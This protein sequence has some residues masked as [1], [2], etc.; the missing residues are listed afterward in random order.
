MLRWILPAGTLACAMFAAPA[1]ATDYDWTPAGQLSQARVS[2]ASTVLEDGRVLVAGGYD[3]VAQQDVATVD[4]YDPGTNTWAPGPPLL[5]PRRVA[6]AATLP[7]GR[8]LVVGGE[9]L[10]DQRKTEIFD[11]AAGRWTRAADTFAEHA[12]IS[13][14]VLD[15]GRVLFLG[16]GNS[17]SEWPGG[18]IFD[19]ATGTW[20]LTADPHEV[21]GA[22]QAVVRLRDG[23]FLVVGG[24]T[25]WSNPIYYDEP[26]AEI[27]DVVSD[28]WTV[29]ARPAY[30][31]E[32]S[33]AALLP[34]GR[35]LVAG[36][37]PGGAAG[38][39]IDADAHRGSEIFDPATGT[40]SL[41]G[42]LLRP[43]AYSS[44][45]VTLPDGRIAAV[46]GAWAT[47]VGPFGQR[48]AGELFYEATAEVYDVASGTWQP[49][50]SMAQAH[51]GAVTKR[52]TD[53]SI[54][55]AGGVT[56][57]NTSL[58][59]VAE[60][61]VPRPVAPAAPTPP[62]TIAP[63]PTVLTRPKAGTLRF[64]APPKHLK[65]SRTGTLTFKVR[66][67]TGGATCTDRLVLR[68]RGRVLAQRD[69][70]VKAGKTLSVRLKLSAAGRRSLRNRTARVT[71]SLRRQGT[72]V[73]VS[74]RG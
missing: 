13:S 22:G 2:V 29:V 25:V 47:I 17:S 42:D 32:G 58:T 49:L 53:G 23:R 18:E 40:W 48:R 68:G 74:V 66:C 33:H 27:Y 35:V 46:G 31:G 70:S 34:D 38:V 15:D 21:G 5:E 6:S 55:V 60:R 71:I 64:L 50:P 36:G 9:D 1:Y 30:S 4:L 28:T 41:T 59:T 7:D 14:F 24:K 16:A 19:P 54:L 44:K 62:V 69:V 11:P 57:P 37:R 67:S 72:K 65:P 51:A 73:N 10:G 56:G 12:G 61:L 43:R 39:M 3:P 8:V 45:F 20:K 26:R 63:K 52:L